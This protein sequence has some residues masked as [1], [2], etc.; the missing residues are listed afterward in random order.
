MSQQT[1]WIERAWRGPSHS[2]KLSYEQEMRNA[3]QP[4]DPRAPHPTWSLTVDEVLVSGDLATARFVT[5]SLPPGTYEGLKLQL[6]PIPGRRIDR[7]TGLAVLA[8]GRL[9]LRTVRVFPTPGTN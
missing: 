6:V 4:D 9:D 5:V 7:V 8:G 3:Q 1:T 2:K